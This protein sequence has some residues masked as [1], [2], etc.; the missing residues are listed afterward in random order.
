MSCDQCMCRLKQ[1]S[2]VGAIPHRSCSSQ[3]SE[4]ARLKDQRQMWDTSPWTVVSRG[5]PRDLQN[6]AD[7]FHCSWF[8]TGSSWLT[9]ILFTQHFF[10]RTLLLSHSLWYLEFLFQHRGHHYEG[11]SR[12]KQGLW[13]QSLGTS[14]AHVH[15]S[16]HNLEPPSWCLNTACLKLTLGVRKVTQKLRAHSVLP[17]A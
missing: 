16:I 15:T 1:Q 2:L 12:A 7:S 5:C 10:F 8:P 9:L 3:K 14:I 11:G 13:Q 4:V 6:R 17:G